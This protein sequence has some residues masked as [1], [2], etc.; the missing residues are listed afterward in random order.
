MPTQQSEDQAA[1]WKWILWLGPGL[2]FS[3]EQPGGPRCLCWGS[4]LPALILT[5]LQA[6]QHVK[7]I[8]LRPLCGGCSGREIIMLFSISL[9]MY[10][11]SVALFLT[12]RAGAD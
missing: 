11:E 12:V 9:P 7:S 3:H 4:W 2:D 5:L 1:P 8:E 10:Q 6:R